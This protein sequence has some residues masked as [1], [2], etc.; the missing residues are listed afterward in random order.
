VGSESRYLVDPAGFELVT[1]RTESECAIVSII[2]AGCGNFVTG[3]FVMVILSPK[4]E[5]IGNFVTGD[6][7]I[8]NLVTIV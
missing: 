8:G 1:T 6:F 3:S 4:Y 2:S 5:K 7:N